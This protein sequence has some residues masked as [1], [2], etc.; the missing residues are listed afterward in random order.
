M[1][2]IATTMLGRRS[3]VGVLF[4]LLLLLLVCVACAGQV[5]PITGSFLDP[6]YDAR[7]TYSNGPGM[8]FTCPQW[9]LKMAEW[10]GLGLEFVVFQDVHDSRYGAY[11]P[12][13]L[14]WMKPW[15]GQCQDVVK[16]VVDSGLKVFLSPEF[17]Y[18]E[19]D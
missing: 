4:L 13:K 6:Y 18:N 7:L 8:K 9:T 15:Q 14:P 1:A 16:A 12:S 19:T 17:V 3:A 11:Y 10:R 5:L 2:M